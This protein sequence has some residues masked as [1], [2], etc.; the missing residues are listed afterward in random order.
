M[1]INRIYKTQWAWLR[2]KLN[3][4]QL[5]MVNTFPAPC[6]GSKNISI[7][8]IFLLSGKISLTERKITMRREY[9]RFSISS[10]RHGIS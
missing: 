5:Q 3:P 1:I 8:S 4:Q 10:N 6:S 9:I 7:G 2:L